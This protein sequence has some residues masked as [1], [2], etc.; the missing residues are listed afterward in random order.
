MGLEKSTAGAEGAKR[1]EGA[2]CTNVL[3]AICL[4][5]VGLLKK[6]LRLVRANT[7]YSVQRP[8]VS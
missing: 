3:Y 5:E 8:N 2:Y 4:G 1:N 6:A 7:Q